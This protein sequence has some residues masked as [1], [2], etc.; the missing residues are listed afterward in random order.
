MQSPAT[1]SKQQP[2]H[3]RQPIIAIDGPAGAGKSTVTRS[4][5]HQLRLLYL[6]TGAMYRAVTW[7]VLEQGIA[8]DDETA[9][10]ELVSQCEIELIDQ[11][12]CYQVRINNQDVTQAIRS[13]NVTANVSAIAA[14]TAVRRTLMK[15][16]QNYGQKGGIIAEG[17]DIGTHVFPEADLKIFLTASVRER[18]KRRQ[19]DLKDR[20]QGDVSLQQLEQAIRER[21]HQDSTR[22]IAPLRQATDAIEIQTDDLTISDVVEKIIALYKEKRFP[23]TLEVQTQSHH[24][25]HCLNQ[26]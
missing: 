9:I 7:L 13:A 26:D 4:I 17:R 6:D 2:S 8:I 21:D 10:A 5:G 23:S 16:Q 11:D 20:G 3:F 14:Q 12:D 18:A 19:K 1:V 22:K 25:N 15:K 24:P